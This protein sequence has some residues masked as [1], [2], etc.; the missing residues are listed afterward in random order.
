MAKPILYHDI[1]NR[2][3]TTMPTLPK[4]PTIIALKAD[5]N[6]LSSLNNLPKDLKFL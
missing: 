4:T 5:Q 2:S 1:S 6:N 3:L